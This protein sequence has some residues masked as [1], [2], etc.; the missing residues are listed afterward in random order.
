MAFPNVV[1]LDDQKIYDN[2][3]TAVLPVG[4]RVEL[5]NGRT[6]RYC[7]NGAV[8]TI[9]SNLQSCSAQVGNANN[10]NL[11]VATS[12]AI[13]DTSI[14]ITN[15]ATTWTLN[16]LKGGSLVNVRV[17]ELGAHYWAIKT[18]TAEAAGSASMTIGLET[19]VSFDTALTAG[20]S[21][22]NI[23]PSL[24]SKTIIAPTAVSG[25]PVGVAMVVVTAVQFGYFQTH[26]VG[27]CKI[28]S[29][30][31]LSAVFC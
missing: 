9:A 17:E 4:Q 1:F 30:D 22:V 23:A 19:G 18:N 7:L 12:V 5:P 14:V 24:Y 21:I 25:I 15:G 13:G 28:D 29:T 6:F 10:D 31:P 16:E 20:T 2:N 11:A 26:G 27:S 3:L 8:A